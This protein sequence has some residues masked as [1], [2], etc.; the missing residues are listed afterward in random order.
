MLADDAAILPIGSIEDLVRTWMRVIET[1]DDPEEI[2]RVLDAAVRFAPERRAAATLAAPLLQRATAAWHR[3]DLYPFLRYPLAALACRWLGD[4][5]RQR[6]RY[7]EDEYFRDKAW[8]HDWGWLTPLEAGAIG[9]LLAA[10]LAG[11]LQAIEAAHGLPLPGVPSHRGSRLAPQVAIDRVAAWEAAGVEAPEAEVVLLLS[12]LAPVGR[13]PGRAAHLRSAAG[14]ALRRALGEAVDDTHLAPALRVAAARATGVA[15]P[16][17]ALRFPE[18]DAASPATLRFIPLSAAPHLRLELSTPAWT[19]PVRVGVR[20]QQSPPEALAHDPDGA[21]ASAPSFYYERH[22]GRTTPRA[23]PDVPMLAAALWTTGWIGERPW[24]W[25][26]PPDN[27]APFRTW[28]SLRSQDLEPFF[29]LGA[30]RLTAASAGHY[31]AR[32]LAAFLEPLLDPFVP[33]GPAALWCLAA[34]LGCRPPELQLVAV[35]A[36][37]AMATDGRLV[38][39]AATGL[40]QRVATL[41]RTIP[42][43]RWAAALARCADSDRLAAWGAADVLKAALL[44]TDGPPGRHT[45]DVLDALELLLDT[46]G[47]PLAPALAERLAGWSLKGKAAQS[48]GRLVARPGGVV[49]PAPNTGAMRG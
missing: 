49:A 23:A 19:P 7:F 1:G 4:D 42:G 39:R 16:D 37:R 38:T 44:H 5:L 24:T 31:V 11:V 28:A 17:L 35:D 43:S 22:S 41:W 34:G 10:R 36:L 8:I 9:P 29:A 2:E 26:T 40:G 3:P 18:P 6:P 25:P 47:G 30:V 27:P 33:A 20:P 12:R 45:A 13:E 32:G 14:L 21:L 48:A 46:T 15:V